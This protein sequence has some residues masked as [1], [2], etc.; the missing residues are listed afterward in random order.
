MFEQLKKFNAN[1][2]D[3][4]RFHPKTLKVATPLWLG[5][6]APVEMLLYNLKTNENESHLTDFTKDQDS[7]K[8][9]FSSDGK[10]LV[11][12][13][14]EKFDIRKPYDYLPPCE[15][16]VFKIPGD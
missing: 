14:K 6:D 16:L 7:P 10:T 9:A 4:E 8:C 12:V 15:V 5:D 1:L 11:V 13:T 2:S 3:L